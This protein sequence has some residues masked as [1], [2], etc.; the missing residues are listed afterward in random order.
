MP[1]LRL[2]RWVEGGGGENATLNVKTKQFYSAL[3][4]MVLK[5]QF[6]QCCAFIDVFIII[7]I[8]TLIYIFSGID[9]AI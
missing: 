1:L 5:K 2:R 9:K 8:K 3:R 6:S 4:R 7:L